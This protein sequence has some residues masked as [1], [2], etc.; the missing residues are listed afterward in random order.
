MTSARSS[1]VILSALGAALVALTA[2]GLALLYCD[3][4]ALDPGVRAVLFTIDICA[5]GAVW[6]AAVTWVRRVSLPSNAIWIVLAV[7]VAMRAIALAAPNVLSTDIYR[8]VWDG[9]VQLAGINPY[10]YIPAAPELAFLR[11]NVVYP[12]INRAD[13]ARTIY[14]LSL[15]HI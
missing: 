1:L 10:R 13:Y 7:A 14:P 11:D 12:Y 2:A 5:A 6:L 9:R 15:I 8:Y 4:S 3:P